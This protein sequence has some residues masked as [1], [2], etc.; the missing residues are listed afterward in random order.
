MSRVVTR[1]FQSPDAA[2]DPRLPPG[3]YDAGRSWPV[4]TAEPRPDL[5]AADWTIAID[6]L[7]ERPRLWTWVEITSLQPTTFTADIHCV[8]AWSRLGLSFTGLPV[9][10]LLD[11]AG[12]AA[13]ATHILAVSHT[14]YTSNLPLAD[15][16]EQRAW[17]VWEAYG[18]P[19]SV[20]HGGPVRLLVP[21][22]YLWKSAKWI[23]GLRLLDH[24]QP[25]FWER[26]GYHHRGDPWKEQRYSGD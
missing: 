21:H 19:L 5:E 15:V 7:V 24:D 25:G 18:Q 6:G 20:D 3:Q 17:I 2:R 26:N 1:G 10:V 13:G 4:L 23:A 22:L 9:A 14:G 16:A 8:T 12:V 11:E